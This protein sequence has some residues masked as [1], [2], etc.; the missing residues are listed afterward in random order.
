MNFYK[1]VTSVF[2]HYENFE[3]LDK[4]WESEKL[5]IQAWAKTLKIPE[6]E[7]TFNKPKQGSAVEIKFLNPVLLINNEQSEDE[8]EEEE[9]EQEQEGEE[10]NN[11]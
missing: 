11:Q 5:I 6:K 7:Y 1:H 8:E 3:Y 2:V 10:K 9:E 4:H